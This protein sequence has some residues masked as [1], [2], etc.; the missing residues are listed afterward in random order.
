[1]EQFMPYLVM[2][3]VFLFFATIVGVLTSRKN[4]N[5]IL[6]G[7]FGGLLFIPT[8]IALAFVRFLCPNC[9]NPLSNQ[10]WKQRE[11]PHCMH[12]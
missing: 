12:A 8:M 4:R 3:T 5:G 2:L 7:L 1:M 11:C 10:Q 9:H 6:W